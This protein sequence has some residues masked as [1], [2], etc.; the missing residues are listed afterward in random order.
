MIAAALPGVVAWAA[1]VDAIEITK[2]KAMSID[3]IFDIINRIVFFGEISTIRCFIKVNYQQL[4]ISV[5]QHNS[6]ALFSRPLR[7]I[8]NLHHDHVVLERW[9][10]VGTRNFTA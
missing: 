7:S 9:L 2:P 4:N 8:Q 5:L 6:P 3:D 10:V 1:A